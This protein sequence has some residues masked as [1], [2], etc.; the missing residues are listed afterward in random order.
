[1][2]IGIVGSGNMGRSLGMLWAERGH[3]VFFGSRNAAKAQSVA[4][5]VGNNAQGGTNDEAVAFTEIIL[6]TAR[7]VMPS[8]LLANPSLLDGK[9]LIDCNNQ[10]IPPEFA[11][12][13]ITESLAE[14]LAKD[15]P[16]ARVVKAFNT[17]AQEVFEVGD[18]TLKAHQVSVFIAGD[19]ADARQIVARLADEIGFS[20]LD[21]GVLR[22]SRLI[23]T[24]ADFIRLIII[25]V[26][27]NPY[28]TISVHNLPSSTTTRLGGRQASEL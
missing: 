1:M 17:M 18:E 16:N 8:T 23:E 15:V 25:G 28:A 2:K 6:W 9:I 26:E 20:P 11:Y 12:P 5:F 4:E 13:E 3:Q 27:K 14:K 19:D 24:V 22:H 7:G 10:E 21:C